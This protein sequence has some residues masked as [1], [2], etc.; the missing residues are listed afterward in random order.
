MS[1]EEDQSTDTEK[2]RSED[3]TEC[4]GLKINKDL[5]ITEDK[6]RPHNLFV[7]CGSLSVSCLSQADVTYAIDSICVS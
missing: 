2:D 3:I 6:C 5:R 4:T 1:T 7:K